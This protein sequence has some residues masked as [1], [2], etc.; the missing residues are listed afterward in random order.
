MT[1][2][3]SLWH[4]LLAG[5]A[6]TTARVIVTAAAAARGGEDHD[7]DGRGGGAATGLGIGALGGVLRALGVRPGALTGPV[8]AGAG[9]MA[10]DTA[11]AAHGAG[12]PSAPQA[13]APPRTV[14]GTLPYLSYGAVTHATLTAL[15]PRDAPVRADGLPPRRAGTRLLARSLLLGL[16]AGSRSSLGLAAPVLARALRSDGPRGAGRNALAEVDM[17]DRAEVTLSALTPAPRPGTL[18]ALLSTGAVVGEI[19]ADKRPSTPS[20]LEGG[21]LGARLVAGAAGSV[22]LCRQEDATSFWPAVAGGLGAVAGAHGGAAW[23]AAASEWMPDWQAALIE[24]AVALSAAAGATL[25]G[26]R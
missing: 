6:G 13:G 9:A 3:T 14:A 7:D 19:V 10:A 24:D 15:E 12:H 25:T 5:A 20:R 26:R 17:A 1:L 16:A 2:V 8:V 18:A 4:G 23:R 22:S 21:G 11:L